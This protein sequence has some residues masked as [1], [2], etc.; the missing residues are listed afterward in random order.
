MTPLQISVLTALIC[1]AVAVGGDVPG[2]PRWL[3]DERTIWCGLAAFIVWHR[4]RRAHRSAR[5]VFGFA[6]L[7]GCRSTKP[8]P[9]A[10][11]ST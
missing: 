7:S 8:I 10:S 1:F 3:R 11:T 4:V 9:S 5:R 2:A 6:V